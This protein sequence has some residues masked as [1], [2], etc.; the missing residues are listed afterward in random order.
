MPGMA[1]HFTT[2][3]ILVL[4]LFSLHS[5]ATS[6][7]GIPLHCSYWTWSTTSLPQYALLTHLYSQWSELLKNKYQVFYLCISNSQLV[8]GT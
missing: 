7:V 6:F 2:N 4:L 8:P 5:I 3:I 1:L